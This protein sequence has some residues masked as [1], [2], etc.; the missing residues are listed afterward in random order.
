M[1]KTLEFKELYRPFDK[2]SVFVRALGSI[3]S[4]HILAV[5]GPSG[6]GKSTLLRMLARIIASEFGRTCT[7]GKTPDECVPCKLASQLIYIHCLF[8]VDPPFHWKPHF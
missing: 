7:G 2:R 1:D 8:T 4:G 5:K 3:E 6:S